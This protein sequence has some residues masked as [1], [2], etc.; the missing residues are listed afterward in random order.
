MIQSLL[1]SFIFGGNSTLILGTASSPSISTTFSDETLQSFFSEDSPSSSSY[2][3]ISSVSSALM[4]NANA[5]NVET[6]VEDTQMIIE[7]MSIE[8]LNELKDLIEKKESSLTL[9]KR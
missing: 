4:N 3:T 9:Y 1:N 7:S 2:L 6:Q 8:E 5:M